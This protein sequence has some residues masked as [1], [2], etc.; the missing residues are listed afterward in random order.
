MPVSRILGTPGKATTEVVVQS[1]I[2]A[3]ELVGAAIGNM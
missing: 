3:G 1:F 2:N